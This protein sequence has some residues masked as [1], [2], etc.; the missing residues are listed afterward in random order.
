[1]PDPSGNYPSAC[2]TA[3]GSSAPAGLKRMSKLSGPFDFHLKTVSGSHSDG[4]KY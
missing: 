2:T 1:M 3:G 4:F